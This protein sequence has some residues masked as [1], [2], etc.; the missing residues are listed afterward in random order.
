MDR[1][2]FVIPAL[3]VIVL[4]AI[5]GSESL[6]KPPPP[7]KRVHVLYWEKWTD[8]EFAAMKNVVDHF[9]KIQ[10]KIQVDVL[11]VSGIQDKTLMA[12]SGNIPPDIAGL[13]GPNVTQYADDHA[14]LPLDDMCREAGI[15]AAQY[16]PAFWNIGVTQGHLYALPS[17]PASVGLH[18]NKD[19]FKNNGF[20]PE[21]PPQ[22][23]EDVYSM[24]E[25]ITKKVDDKVTMA[26]FLPA[27][28]GWWNWMWGPL[29]G[30]RWYDDNGHCTANCK[31]NVAAYTFVQA[32][33]KRFGASQVTSFKSG[34]GPFS[35]PQNGFLAGHLAME[36]QGVWMY[37]FITKFAPELHWGAAPLPYPADR[38]D[39]ANSTIIDLDVLCIP[40]GA[41]HVK[42]AFEFI[43]YVQS[44]EGMEML[45]LGQKKA[46]PLVKVSPEFFSKHPNPFIKMFNDLPSGKNAFAVPKLGIWPEY[47]NEI[48]AMFDDITLIKKTPQQALDDLQARM[49]PKLDEYL[50][51][52][53]ER[54][55]S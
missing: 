29:F 30:G 55:E 7:D 15:T 52:L 35:S 41:K 9:N 48:D 47:G 36:P 31:E 39:L 51:R 32:F 27:E 46:S 54:G 20:D 13:Y 37:N 26:G 14:V 21:K 12:I 28:P 19:I 16:V 33:S 49:Q 45:C 23:W 18:W 42:E 34:F 44:Q 3:G 1:G 50:H 4:A 43:K 40:R 24:S 5:F 6:T 8:F 53:K 38:P 10:D 17:T 11:S 25:K 2:A 22:T